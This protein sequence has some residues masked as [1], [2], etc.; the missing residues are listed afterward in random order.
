MLSCHKIH[1]AIAATLLCLV[2]TVA[3]GFSSSSADNI[4]IYWGQNSY[5]AATGTSNAQQRLSYYCSSKS[6]HTF[7]PL[8]SK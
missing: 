5:G 8:D 2:T 4:A 3:G 6:E 7:R 1:A